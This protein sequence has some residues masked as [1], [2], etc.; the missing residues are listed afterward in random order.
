[1]SINYYCSGFDNTNAFFKELENNFKN[2]LTDTKSILLEDTK[3]K[4]KIVKHNCY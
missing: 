4:N 2:E 1:M 3:E